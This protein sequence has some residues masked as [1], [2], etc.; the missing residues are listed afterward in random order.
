MNDFLLTLPCCWVYARCAI[1]K[2]VDGFDS[3][4]SER[5]WPLCG[6]FYVRNLFALLFFW[7]GILGSLTARRSLIRSV[8]PIYPPAPCPARVAVFSKS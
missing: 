1:A 5:I 7:V 2:S 3:L 4:L 6:F 8:N